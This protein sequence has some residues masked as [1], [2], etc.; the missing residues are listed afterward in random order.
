MVI[1]KKWKHRELNAK[2]KRDKVFNGI[3]VDIADNHKDFHCRKFIPVS[4]CF[5][6]KYIMRKT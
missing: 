2:I 1:E 5:S 6:D 3:D 4:T